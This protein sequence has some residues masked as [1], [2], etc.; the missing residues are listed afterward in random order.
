[1]HFTLGKSLLDLT[2]LENRNRFSE[3]KPYEIY[4]NLLPKR[5]EDLKKL[6]KLKGTIYEK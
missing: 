5:E 4:Q 2:Y 1:M 3:D 6:E